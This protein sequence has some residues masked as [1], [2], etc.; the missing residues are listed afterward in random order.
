MALKIAALLVVLAV[1]ETQAASIVS[2][3]DTWNYRDSGLFLFAVL[4]QLFYSR[5]SKAR[6][7]F[8]ILFNIERFPSSEVVAVIVGADIYAHARF[9]ILF[10]VE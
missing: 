6:P 9:N 8:N 1:L 2:E 3:K 10:N 4:V 5:H 7:C